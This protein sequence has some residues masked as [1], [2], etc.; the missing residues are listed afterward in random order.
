MEDAENIFEEIMADGFLS[1]MEKTINPFY[2]RISKRKRK[3]Y[4]PKHINI[5]QLKTNKKE[6]KIFITERNN[7][8]YSEK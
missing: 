1:L 4:I 5:N 6:K 8:N 7:I 3:K 2:L